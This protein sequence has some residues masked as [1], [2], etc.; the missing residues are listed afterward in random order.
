MPHED[1]RSQRSQTQRPRRPFTTI[2]AR[3]GR[4][5]LAALLLG[6]LPALAAPGLTQRAHAAGN[7]VVSTCNET[8]LRT[9]ITNASG[10][11]TVTFACSGT[12]TV[13]AGAAA[14]SP[15]LAT[16]P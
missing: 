2:L 12:I 1:E 13:T 9:A 16:R 6:S 15:S 3:P 8:S 10:G 7:Q 14:L 11:G 5:A 4:L